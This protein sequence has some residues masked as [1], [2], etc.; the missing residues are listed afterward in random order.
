V[1]SPSGA[2]GAGGRRRLAGVAALALVV[3]VFG[4]GAPAQS[5]PGIA[6]LERHTL[7]RGTHARLLFGADVGRV[8]TGEE[9]VLSVDLLTNRE[10]LVLGRDAGLSSVTV[11]LANGAV[12]QH[13]FVVQ[14]DLSVLVSALRQIHPS[15]RVEA[16]PDRDAVVLRGSVPDVSFSV[17]AE[18]AARS[19]LEAGG[20]GGQGARAPL[21]GGEA[22][23]GGAEGAA[24]A[25]ASEAEA[26]GMARPGAVGQRRSGRVINLIQVE[27]LPARLEERLD[28]AAAQVGGP[29]IRTTRWLRGDVPGEED[30]FVLD[31]EVAD[32]RRLVRLLSVAAL[33]VCGEAGEVEVRA[34]ES[35]AL[36][37]QRGEAGDRGGGSGIP[38]LGGG[39]SSFELETGD[40][41]N[42]IRENIARASVLELCG[43]QLL[44]FVSVEDLPQVRVAVRIYEVNRSR[45]DSWTPNIDAIAGDIDQGALLPTLAGDRL[46]GGGAAQAGG[47]DLDLQNAVSLLAGSFTN[48]LQV[49]G[50]RVAID[51]L[52]SLL[53]DD[54]IARS[55]AEPTL[56][57]LSGEI[58]TFQ[59]GGEIPVPTS[60]TTGAADRVFNSVF[61]APFGVQLGIRPLVGDDDAI[62]LDVTPQ[63]VRPDPGLTSAIRESTGQ[64]LE[65]TAFESRDLAT[66]ARLRDGQALVL[67]GLLDRSLSEADAFTPWAHRIPGLGWLFRSFDVQDEDF[68]LVIVVTPAILREPPARAAL[69]SFPEGPELLSPVVPAP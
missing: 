66:T 54:G 35:G 62:T 41:S 53:A 20:A 28:R 29:E 15:L 42:R 11:W 59:V 51:A 9:S 48:Q 3:V 67:G 63:V 40:L 25:Q 64:V 18:A 65:T 38:G 47:D 50:S 44:S 27:V 55:L 39:T 10:L 1:L 8:A 33:L 49:A 6:V 60:V 12:E 31:G 23:S 16:A 17:A 57:V 68:E 24:A 34:D 46:Q 30:V 69:W 58:A 2:R 14:R 43:G 37:R 52:F 19:Y 26:L 61:F 4:R 22:G 5:P 56:M 7:V 32:Q 45:L 13:V 21:L 36:A